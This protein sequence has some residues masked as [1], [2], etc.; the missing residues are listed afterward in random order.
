MSSDGFDLKS[1]QATSPERPPQFEH[2]FKL[3]SLAIETAWSVFVYTKR[4]I[5]NALQ[6]ALFN[7]QSLLLV[8]LLLICTS[9]YVHNVAPSMLDNRRNG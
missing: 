3:P 4:N 8:I 5:A 6:S 1:R 9:T 7:F 2:D